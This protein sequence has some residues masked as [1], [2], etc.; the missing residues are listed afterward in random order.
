MP[1][2]IPESNANSPP[3]I[4]WP[5]R[6]KYPRATTQKTSKEGEGVP[7]P[8]PAPAPSSH[9]RGTRYH[10][11][12]PS[13]LLYWSHAQLF[14]C[15]PFSPSSARSS[16]RNLP[17]PLSVMAPLVMI[18]AQCRAP[19]QAPKRLKSGRIPAEDVRSSLTR[20]LPECGSNRIGAS[21]LPGF[22]CIEKQ[23]VPGRSSAPKPSCTRNTATPATRWI[24][25]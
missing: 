24:P 18:C 13:S 5:F 1:V 25:G 19:G 12:A 7:S 8:A 22:P 20:R 23:K 17:S 10:L 15:E 14:G 21:R 2:S 11:R 3:K 6:I 16:S 4:A 9:L